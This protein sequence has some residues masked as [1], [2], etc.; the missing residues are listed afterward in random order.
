MSGWR[1]GR[2]P[3]LA[4][5][6]A[7]LAAPAVIPAMAQS[8]RE[9]TDGL[10]RHLVLRAP[11][12]RVV[13]AEANDLLLLALVHP[14]PVGLLVGWGGVGRFDRPLLDKWQRR[15]PRL[16]H[17]PTIGGD[18][19]DSV[20]LE[21]ILAL[22]PDLVLMPRLFS[23]QGM[24]V[25]QLEEAGVT[26]AFVSSP[27]PG[28]RAWDM[29]PVVTIM[30]RL[31]DRERQAG[32]YA[33]FYRRRI[34]RIAARVAGAGPG[35]RV[36]VEAHAGRAVCCA[37]PGRQGSMGDFIDLA[38]GENIAAPVLPVP[39]GQI[40]LEYAVSR[41]PEVYIGTGGA[42]LAS[43]GGLV[44]GP[45]QREER[46]RASL[47]ATLRRPGIATLPAVRNGRAHGLW[48]QLVS[49]PISVLAAEVMAQWIRPELFG[50]LDPAASLA[51][52][53]ERFL[54]VSL[55]GC[56]WVSATPPVP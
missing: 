27:S 44:L 12:R 51:T 21:R 10:G 5:A 55:R 25:R 2:R 1:T 20:S 53:N 47:A 6:A 31:L 43:E 41:A 42:Y 18:T 15:E 19:P 54:P 45:G 24:L 14:D 13:L 33:D 40:S 26:V 48:H 49:S 23:P 37:S 35:P 3:V 29:A 11:V 17:L 36:M 56:L 4:A 7:M 50:D 16:G 30:G 32:E 39:I 52:L 9:V 46:A 22:S 34:E 38:G 28:S 8:A